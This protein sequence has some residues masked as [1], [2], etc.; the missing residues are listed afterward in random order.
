MSKLIKSTLI[1]V[2]LVGGL[3]VQANAQ[4]SSQFRNGVVVQSSQNFSPRFQNRGINNARFVNN[5]RF[6]GQRGFNNRRFVGQRGF[7]NRRF[8]GQRGFNNRRGFN[9]SRFINRGGYNG[10]GS[11]G[12]G[13]GISIGVSSGGFNR[14]G[15]RRGISSRGFG[16]RGFG[17]HRRY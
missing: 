4:S 10:Y 6:V 9:N 12:F 11:F 5:R 13:S 8:V 15:N 16:R 2:A 3:A 7:N 1:A 17:G 14:F